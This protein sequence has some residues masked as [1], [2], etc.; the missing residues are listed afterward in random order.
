MADQGAE[1]LLSPFL[2]KQRFA[3]ALPF[4]RGKVLD[5]GCGSGGLCRYLAPDNYLGVDLDSESLRLASAQYPA[6][7]FQAQ[8][9]PLE[10]KFDT[11]IALAVIEH[12]DDPRAFLH[13]LAAR[14]AQGD[15]GRVVITTPH[16]SMEVVHTLGARIG[17]FSR[18][19]N[20]EHEELL[21]R[22]ALDQ[23]ARSV[24]LA[25]EHYR[26]F[27]FGA[28]QVCVFRRVSY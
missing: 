19:A 5:V 16:P 25:I 3:A 14:L 17:L 20:E 10:I 11:V 18:H 6:Y 26:R 28:N 27:L 2:R 7:N 22:R 4:L 24:G 9:P 13:E 12:V 23:C 1:G 8:F 15:Q 21:D